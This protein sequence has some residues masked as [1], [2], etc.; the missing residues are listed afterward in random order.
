MSAFDIASRAGTFTPAK[1]PKL[2][3]KP[4]TVAALKSGQLAKPDSRPFVGVLTESPEARA[5][6]AQIL[7]TLNPRS[8]EAA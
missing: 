4:E 2:K 6:T 3:G 5:K 1:P 8:K 7:G